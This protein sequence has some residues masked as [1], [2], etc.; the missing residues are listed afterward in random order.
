M[1]TTNSGSRKVIRKIDLR[2][3]KREG[4]E[5]ERNPR[6]VEYAI[7]RQRLS[8]ITDKTDDELLDHLID[9]GFNESNLEAMRYAPIAEVAW[10]SG[11]V[12]QF[13]QVFAVSV[14]MST[15]MLNAPMASDLFQSWLTKRPPKTLWMVWEQYTLDCMSR[16]DRTR[17]QEFGR[18]LYEVAMRVALASGGLLDQGEVC[19]AEQAVLDRIARVYNLSP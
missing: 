19:A 3:A 9:L 4:A 18:C 7:T 14:A 10:A 15:D 12:T 5:T 1:V 8:S 13:E 16:S 2:L 11:K 6:R 17:G